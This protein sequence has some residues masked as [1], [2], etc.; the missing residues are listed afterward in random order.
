MQI[1]FDNSLIETA[2]TLFQKNR[3]SWRCVTDIQ[4]MPHLPTAIINTQETHKD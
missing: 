1:F 4:N 2:E 3:F